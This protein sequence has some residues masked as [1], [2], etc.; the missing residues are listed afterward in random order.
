MSTQYKLNLG[1]ECA[2]LPAERHRIR[3]GDPGAAGAEEL[4]MGRRQFSLT[5][6]GSSFVTK[7]SFGQVTKS[8]IVRGHAQVDVGVTRVTSK[9]E[10]KLF[11]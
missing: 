11:V 8:L 10:L 9:S 1:S 2:C 3:V 4:G 5:H 6:T 7:Q